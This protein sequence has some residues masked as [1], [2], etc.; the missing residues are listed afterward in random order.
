MS[1]NNENKKQFSLSPYAKTTAKGVVIRKE[2]GDVLLGTGAPLKPALKT[3]ANKVNVP[4]KAKINQVSE[5]AKK[6]FPIISKDHFKDSFGKVDEAKSTN[7]RKQ[8]AIIG[9]TKV[10]SYLKMELMETVPVYNK[11]T[12]TTDNTESTENTKRKS[13]NSLASHSSM[14]SSGFRP[15]S[16]QAE[17]SEEVALKVHTEKEHIET[18]DWPSKSTVKSS[19]P[20]LSFTF[21]PYG[22]PKID[23][24]YDKRS[25]RECM[26]DIVECVPLVNHLTLTSQMMENIAITIEEGNTV[27]S[28]TAINF[29]VARMATMEVI[30]SVGYCCVRTTYDLLKQI[31]LTA[32]LGVCKGE[33][34]IQGMLNA[35]DDAKFIM[36][37]F[38]VFNGTLAKL[39]SWMV[40]MSMS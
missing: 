11:E 6:T 12:K 7:E 31:G 38:N 2:V 25:L 16:P 14:K 22:L 13:L 10:E 17:A 20:N 26:F 21:N 29:K 39:V 3:N 40:R 19:L 5:A 24:D 30:Y 32:M 8:T 18:E 33:Q 9:K 1:K 37:R 23:A 28:L 15:D 36:I 35:C 34:D 4:V 27:G